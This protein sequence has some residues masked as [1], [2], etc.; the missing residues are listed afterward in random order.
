[1]TFEPL[2]TIT[3]GETDYNVADLPDHTKRKVEIY[4]RLRKTAEEARFE[5]IKNDAALR[6]IGAQIAQDINASVAERPQGVE[7][8]DGETVEQ[9]PETP[10][11]EQES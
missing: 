10:S 6:D 1:M 5:V 9:T 7:T 11:E 4:D 2:T 3:I 8:A